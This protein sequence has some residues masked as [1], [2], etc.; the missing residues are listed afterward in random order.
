MI[1]LNELDLNI[2]YSTNPCGV[3]LH[4]EADEVLSRNSGVEE[5]VKLTTYTVDSSSKETSSIKNGKNINSFHQSEAS[6]S[7]ANQFER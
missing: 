5:S 6:G 4:S 1:P 3:K 2:R 7:L